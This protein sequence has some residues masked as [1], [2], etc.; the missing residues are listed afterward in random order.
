MENKPPS[1]DSPSPGGQYVSANGL[2]IYYQESGIGQPLILVHGATDTHRLWDS[3]LANFQDRFR[4]IRPDS[5]G[6]GRTFNPSRKL[7]YC[8]MADDLAA[9]IGELG[10]IKPFLF[11]Y[12]DGGQAVLD[13]GIRYPDLP[14]ALVIGGAWYQFSKE[15]QAAIS[16]M[17]FVAPGVVDWEVYQGQAPL[18]W[19]DRLR[20]AHLDPDPDYP[21]ILLEGLAR[22]WWTTLDYSEAD[23]QKIKIPTLILIGEKDE[24]IPVSEAQELAGLIPRAE[25]TVIPGATHNRVLLPGGKFGDFILRFL[26][27]RLR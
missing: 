10:L 16:G 27:S 1:I 24:I 20:A 15:Y 14:G 26:D 2:E 11:G 13:L 23:F 25:L 6:H 4:V 8:L 18:D 3:H 22:M 21:G 9:M 19:Q 12:S 5:R 17:G 7:S